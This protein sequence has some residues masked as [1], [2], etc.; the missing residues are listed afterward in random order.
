MKHEFGMNPLLVHI[1]PPMPSDGNKNLQNLINSGL[2]VLNIPNPII[3]KEI[4]FG[5]LK[6]F[7]D[8]LMS[9]MIAVRA[10]VFQTAIRYGIKMVMGRRR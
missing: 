1:E 6:D 8:P 9:W 4:A 10:V 3:S 7:G 2:I 5:E